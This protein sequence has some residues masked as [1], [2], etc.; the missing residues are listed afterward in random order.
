M[1]V[2]IASARSSTE[3]LD[4]PTVIIKFSSASTT[5]PNNSN[6]EYVNATSTMSDVAG[7]RLVE[8]RASEGKRRSG[9]KKI[10]DEFESEKGE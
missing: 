5:D 1:A 4:R 7:R 6:S 10:G 8:G 2:V 9:V 3:H